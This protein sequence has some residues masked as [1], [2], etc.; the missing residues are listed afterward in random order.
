MAHGQK[1]LGTA[2]LVNTIDVK[3]AAFDFH[4]VALNNWEYTQDELLNSF[5]YNVNSVRNSAVNFS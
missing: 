3:S 5:I 2:A 4:Q 1:M